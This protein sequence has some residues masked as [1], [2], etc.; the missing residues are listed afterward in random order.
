[1]EEEEEEEE[2]DLEADDAD[3]AVN[4]GNEG[5]GAPSQVS[6]IRIE[7]C[8]DESLSLAANAERRELAIDND[9]DDESKFEAGICTS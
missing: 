9:E 6:G 1:M 8:T 3:D 7:D 2:E 5:G 4:S